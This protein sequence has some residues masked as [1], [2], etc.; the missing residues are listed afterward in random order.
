[1]PIKL[2][3]TPDGLT[4]EHGA[5]WTLTDYSEAPCDPDCLDVECPAGSHADSCGECAEIIY[6][7]G[8]YLCLDGGDV[9]CVGC[10]E[11]LS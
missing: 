8:H 3:R 2:T 9:T 11:V 1:M 7:G 6:E 4:D 10:V 5:V